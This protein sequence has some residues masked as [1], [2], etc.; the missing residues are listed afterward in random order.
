MQGLRWLQMSEQEIHEFLGQGGTGVISFATDRDTS[1]VSIPV[2]YGYNE[3]VESFYFRLSIPPN[4]RKE[5]LVERGVTFVTYDKTDEGWQSVVATGQLEAVRDAPYASSTV[6][7]MWGIDIP[8]VDIFERPR[9]DMTFRDYQLV[10][11]QVT[12]RKEVESE[13]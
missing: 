11:E 1:P 12:G 7:G 2:S 6:Q 8:K 4:S 10:P 3:D 9:E 5:E 13:S